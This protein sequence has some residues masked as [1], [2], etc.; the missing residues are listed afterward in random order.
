MVPLSSVTYQLI[1][2]NMNRI[3]GLASRHNIPAIYPYSDWVR[4]GGLM[5]YGAKAG[6]ADKIVADYVVRILQGAKPADLPVAQASKFELV[7]N[8]QTA[9]LL[10]LA[11]PPSLPARADEVIE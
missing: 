8:L 10:D 6:T 3:L 4:R 7:I 5:S 9:K 11:V 2:T 1:G